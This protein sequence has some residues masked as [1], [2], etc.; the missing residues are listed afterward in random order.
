MKNQIRILNISAEDAVWTISFMI[1]QDFYSE[2][3]EYTQIES[4]DLTMPFISPKTKAFNLF[5][6]NNK[7]FK[8]KF[9]EAAEKMADKK[10]VVFPIVVELEENTLQTSR[11]QTI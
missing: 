8:K 4:D 3:F 5:F 9:F 2:E 10:R 7:A 1:G 11:L 6:A